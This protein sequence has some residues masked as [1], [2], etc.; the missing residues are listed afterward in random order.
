M[1]VRDIYTDP[2]AEAGKIHD[3]S[4]VSGCETLTVVG[5]FETL[6]TDTA[7]TV[8]RLF[9]DIPG[10]VIPK[11]FEIYNDAIAGATDLDIGVYKVDKGVVVDKDLF[12]DGLDISAG[13][14]IGS[15]ANGLSAI[16]ID[17]LNKSIKELVEASL[18]TTLKDEVYDICITTNADITGAG[19]IAARLEY[20]K[21]V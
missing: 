19:T 16:G 7:A 2:N 12:A 5:V 10:N 8:Y 13:N 18:S 21:N 20:I 4:K 15:P 14:A 1:A 17:A 9:K 11:V 6:A 3:T